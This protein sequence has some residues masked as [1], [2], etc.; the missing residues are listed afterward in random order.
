MPNW[1][2]NECSF[3]GPTDRVAQ[4]FAV[5]TTHDHT[6]V[7]FNKL[8]PMPTVLEKLQT[9]HTIINGKS[10]KYWFE[11][12]GPDGKPV[13]RF[14]T[15]EEDSQLR[16][17]GFKDWR[18]W[19]IAKWGCKW[20][21]SESS[22]EPP[23]LTSKTSH[24]TVTFHTPWGPPDEFYDVLRDRFPDITMSLFY[25]EPGVQAVGYL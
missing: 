2:F 22:V 18:D 8:V 9:G 3:S 20:D 24:F 25:H 5:I 12:P 10:A 16:S 21:A 14:L 1:C 6:A 15:P 19:S 17:T 23:D 4:L 7:T 13:P 11:E